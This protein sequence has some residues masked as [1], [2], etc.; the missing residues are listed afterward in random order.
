MSDADIARLPIHPNP[1]AD[2]S[3]FNFEL[4]RSKVSR[5]ASRAESRR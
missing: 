2:Q 5:S 3:E 4:K 1:I